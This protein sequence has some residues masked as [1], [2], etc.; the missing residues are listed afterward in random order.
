MKSL[1]HLTTFKNYLAPFLFVFISTLVINFNHSSLAQS[2][3]SFIIDSS[4]FSTYDTFYSTNKLSQIP[5]DY[6]LFVDVNDVIYLAYNKLGLNKAN[7]ALNQS[8]YHLPVLQ[9]RSHISFSQDN[10]YNTTASLVRKQYNQNFQQK[11]IE[12]EFASAVPSQYAKLITIIALSVS[13]LSGIIYCGWLVGNIPR[14]G[15]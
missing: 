6:V 4:I 9:L 8:T 15:S 14:I 12:M 13:L 2:Q 1:I 3:N 7:S 5:D 10:I 11:S